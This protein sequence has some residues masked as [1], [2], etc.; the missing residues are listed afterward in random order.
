MEAWR[1]RT[2]DVAWRRPDLGEVEE[3]ARTICA[4]VRRRGDAAL[5]DLTRRFDGVD[6][7]AVGLEVPPGEVAAAP[8]TVDAAL[9]SAIEEAAARIEAFHRL[10]MP[11]PYR[12]AAAG[13]AWLG[14]EIRPLERVG[15][16]VPGGLARYP[17][18]VLM[19]AVPARLAGVRHVYLCTPPGPGGRVDAAVLAAAAVA[20]V[21]RVFR[22]GGAQAV[23]AMAYGTETVP[24][25]DKVVG[26]GNAYVMAA[27][28]LVA[29]EVGIDGLYGPSEVA[30]VADGG[31]DA[32]WVAADLIAQAEHDRRALAVC[33]TPDRRLAEGVLAALARQLAA[34]PRR[35]LAGAALERGGVVLTG[36]L[37]EA[38]ALA[39]DLA[40]EHLHLYIRD[41]E[42]WLPRV[43]RA[44]AV[45]LGAWATVP[46]GDYA[47]GTNHVL[48]TG[49]TAR[50]ASG[51]GVV[52]F[53]RRMH[54]FAGSRDAV[55]AWAPASLIL[56][57][58]EGLPGHAAAIRRRL[59]A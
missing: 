7:T 6:L 56:A 34:A 53:V 29:G 27:K 37:E 54:V 11:R 4:E 26:P 20:G 59:E 52:D 23:A 49:G 14:E 19:A 5:L 51:L 10:Q 47:V 1:R 30:V 21:E 42:A 55:T 32:D 3:A 33:F 57:S 41:A 25:V 40:P 8:A 44:G 13:G 24:A 22:V 36:D 43:R 50:F 15:V 2:A 18:T 48:P 28:R 58:C 46:A 12:L 35:E 45:F 9:R 17:S 39:D 16:Y 31:A 38:V